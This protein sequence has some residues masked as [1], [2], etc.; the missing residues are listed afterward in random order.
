MAILNEKLVK[1]TELLSDGSYHDGTSLGGTLGITRA[2]VWKLFKKLEGYGVTLSSLKGK[3]YCLKNPIAL[4]DRNKI[5]SALKVT[6][7]HL[8][9]LEKVTSTNDY[10]K[11]VARSSNKEVSVCLSETQT[12]GR[13]RYLRSWYSP[14]GQ[15]I[16]L[17]VL[18]PFEKDISELSGLSLIVGLS[19]FDALKELIQEK[20]DLL[21][22]K[23]PNDILIKEEKLAGILIDIKA[24]SNGY[25]EAVIGIGLNVNMTKEKGGEVDQPWT[26]LKETFHKTF[27]RSNLA[28]LMLN[29]LFKHLEL[30]SKN[31]LSF[32]KEEWKNVDYLYNK[33]SV[34][35][36]GDKTQ[37][38][39]GAGIND[40]GHFLLKIEDGRLL[41]FSSGD[42]KILR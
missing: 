5:K 39:I 31:G 17:S 16:Y 14:F 24:Q 20:A 1:L 33:K 7:P 19:L 13:G 28:A 35:V 4:L 40:L 10:F 18:Y 29:S 21:K 6:V 2:G 11:D 23:W 32:F 8:D 25:C 36:I 12:K 37:T 3:G 30:F 38:G 34:L 27:D 41:S 22:V 15:N 26:S 42:A 9:V